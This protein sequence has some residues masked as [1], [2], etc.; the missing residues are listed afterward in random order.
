MQF[1][2]ATSVLA[3]AGSPLLESVKYRGEDIGKG[4]NGLFVMDERGNRHGLS[5]ADQ[6]KVEALKAGPLYAEIRYSGNITIAADYRVPFTLTVDMP[7]S[8]TG[9]RLSASVKDP[10][11]RLRS[12]AIDTPF[13]FIAMPLIWD[14]GTSHW[15]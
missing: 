4:A 7:N 10:G 15:T 8:K 5:D 11:M 3:K 12:V 2:L 1:R 9:V 13:A 6:V 14:F